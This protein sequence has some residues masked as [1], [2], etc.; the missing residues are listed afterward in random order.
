MRLPDSRRKLTISAEPLLR[1]DVL[2]LTIAA[3][4]SRRSFMPASAA[5]RRVILSQPAR[6]APT[7]PTPTIRASYRKEAAEHAW[8]WMQA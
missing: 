6:C 1:S 5:T 4:F 2:G 7:S 3:P 8:N